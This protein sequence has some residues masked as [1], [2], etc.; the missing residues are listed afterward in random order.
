M[1]DPAPIVLF[2]YNRPWHTEQTLKAL[3]LNV[4]AKE[5]ILYI[6]A[7]GPKENAG[8]DDLD[9]I[10][11]TRLLL[12][13]QQ[14]CGTVQVIESQHNK[15]LADSIIHGVSD[16]VNKHGRV[17]V[18]E[19]DI[20]TSPWFLTYMNDALNLYEEESRVMH[21]SG[22][23]YPVKDSNKLPGTFFYNTATCYG[24][25]TWKRSWDL[26]TEKDP[27]ILYNKIIEKYSW[28]EYNKTG[29]NSFQEQLMNNMN[30]LLKTWAIKWY[31]TIFLNGGFSLHPKHS[32]VNNIGFDG[33]G[34]NTINIDIYRWDKLSGEIELKRMPIVESSAALGKVIA[35]NKL[36]FGNRR[37]KNFKSAI[38][39]IIPS[40][41]KKRLKQLLGIHNGS[42]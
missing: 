13:Q 22:Y 8:K 25:G 20:V 11:E 16:V 10:R 7:D 38:A 1:R 41:V 21:V 35:F 3:A 32:F 40:P 36:H 12:T 2:V 27:T 14:W 29:T 34:E 24:W 15:G 31:S 23:W 26:F 30:G 4:I 33:S 37:N 6:Y 18:L 19:D 9:K 42:E 39:G 5:S 28:D 17:I